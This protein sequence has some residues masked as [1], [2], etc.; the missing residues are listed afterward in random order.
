M[1][2]ALVALLKRSKDE[3]APL[4]LKRGISLKKGL[5]FAGA[6]KYKIA[7]EKR[8]CLC[9]IEPDRVKA[10]ARADK[11]V[12]PDSLAHY[13]TVLIAALKEAGDER[14]WRL[15]QAQERL[16][17]GQNGD[18]AMPSDIINLGNMYRMWLREEI[19]ARDAHLSRTARSM[20]PVKPAASF[21]GAHSHLLPIVR[22]SAD[23]G[24]VRIMGAPGS[25]VPVYRPLVPGLDLCLGYDSDDN[26]LRLGAHD[27]KKWDLSEDQAFSLALDNLRAQSATPMRD[28]GHGLFESAWNDDYSASRLLLTELMVRQAGPGAPVAMVPGKDVLLLTCDSNDVGMALMV[29]RA[30][31]IMAQPN[32]LA[33]LML[34]LEDGQWRDFVPPARAIKL[35][36]LRKQWEGELYQQQ[37]Q[38]MGKKYAAAGKHIFVSSYMVGGGGDDAPTRSACSWSK[39]VLSLLPKTDIL[40]LVDPHSDQSQAVV[41]NW[42]DALPI[43][44]GLMHATL[45]EPPR[46]K[47]TRFPDPQQ[48][49]LLRQVAGRVSA[50]GAPPVP[51]GSLGT[52]AAQAVRRLLRR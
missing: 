33:P 18:A 36:H 21:A 46:Y 24:Q 45:D 4:L 6:T 43:V 41:V 15:D 30:E 11:A 49:D 28:C 42:D 51:D 38:L 40:C 20:Q 47:V 48:L 7:L 14:P 35:S 2:I 5:D 23:R 1:E 22:N 16:H 12:V 34:R 17:T 9:A 19:S 10:G 27:L 39:G 32:A 52:R 37:K 44:G 8:G 31:T 13:G 25:E 50:A 29:R 26:I 3:V